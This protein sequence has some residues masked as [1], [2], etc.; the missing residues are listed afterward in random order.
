MGNHMTGP[1]RPT[2]DGR[3]L[4]QD[5]LSYR[6]LT[7]RIL[8]ASRLS[9]WRRNHAKKNLRETRGGSGRFG[10]VIHQ[11]IAHCHSDTVAPVEPSRESANFS[12]VNLTPCRRLLEAVAHNR[13]APITLKGNQTVVVVRNCHVRTAVASEVAHSEA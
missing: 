6:T 7:E 10:A 13:H 3:Q 9:T 12:D 2:R 11:W 8:A 4:P 5:C 1:S